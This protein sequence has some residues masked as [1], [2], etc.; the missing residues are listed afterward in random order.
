MAPS[1]YSNKY[2]NI[3]NFSLRNKIHWNFNRSSSI[4]IQENV[5]K[6]VVC[7]MAAIL[8]RP[9]CVTTVRPEEDGQDCATD[10]FGHIF[11][12]ENCAILT[13]SPLKY[14]PKGPINNMPAMVQIMVW[15]QTGDK[16]SSKL[17]RR[18]NG[19]A[20]IFH[21]PRTFRSMTIGPTIP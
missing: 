2:L 1:Y 15:W 19:N 4:F 6:N 9:Q 18:V 16:P 14:V 10:I 5:F 8:F 21:H 20:D 12:N 3:V 13:G 7:E 11:L 17:T